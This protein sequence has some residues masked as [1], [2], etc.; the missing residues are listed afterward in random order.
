MHCYIYKI[1]FLIKQFS[2]EITKVITAKEQH[3][4]RFR[5]LNVS[6]RATLCRIQR[7]IHNEEKYRN[8]VKEKQ[9]II[10]FLLFV[11]T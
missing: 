1:M 7:E 5:M 11:D 8:Q 10:C 2:R 3:P 4:D 9:N 6:S